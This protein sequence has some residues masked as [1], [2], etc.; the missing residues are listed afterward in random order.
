MPRPDSTTTGTSSFPKDLEQRAVQALLQ[1]VVVPEDKQ[2]QPN[3]RPF[4][5]LFHLQCGNAF[6]Q[7]AIQ[8]GLSTREQR[9]LL[10]Q[11]LMGM[12][13]EPAATFWGALARLVESVLHNQEHVPASAFVNEEED[14]EEEAFEIVPDA[15]SAAGLQFLQYAA[16][17]VSKYFESHHG[18]KLLPS[19]LWETA[20][21]LHDC[22][23]QLEDPA[24]GPEAVAAHAA[25]VSLC[26][27]WWL[28]QGPDA[29]QVIVQALPCLVQAVLSLQQPQPGGGTQQQGGSET[30][31]RAAHGFDG[32]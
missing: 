16:R 26:E 24:W 13:P 12:K 6:Q 25:I 18:K 19:G 20:K 22:L 14:D 7:V 2:P 17:C 21:A 8:E 5:N 3:K 9:H 1:A 28:K 29:E 23:D 4:L 10:F 32:D 11:A 15:V 31:V 30:P 27:T